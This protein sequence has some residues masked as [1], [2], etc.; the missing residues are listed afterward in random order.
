MRRTINTLID[1]VNF[2]SNLNIRGGV[3][4]TRGSKGMTVTLPELPQADLASF[5]AEVDSDSGSNGGYYNCHLQ[6]LDATDWNSATADQLD[7][8]GDSVIVL[9]LSEIGTSVHNLDA[10]DLIRCWYITD[11]EG[12]ARLVGNEVFGRHTFGEW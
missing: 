3:V 11:D 7:D 4:T 12:N 9:N 1:R 10:G 5:I 6:T 8:I 2:L